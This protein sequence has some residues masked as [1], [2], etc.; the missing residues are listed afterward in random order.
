M[1]LFEILYRSPA[2]Y[3]LASTLGFRGYWRLWQRLALRYV[4]RG[5]L[6]DLG[7]GLG[8]LTREAAASG[9]TAIGIDRSPAMVEA[10]R[11]RVA[12]AVK[13]PAFILADVRAL[14]FPDGV[15]D[16]L[17][18]A[19]PTGV[20]FQPAVGREAFRVLKPGS[21]AAIVLGATL[22]PS[23]L[24]NAMA[25]VAHRA[26]YGSMAGNVPREPPD[27]PFVA[28]GLEQSYVVVERPSW[29]AWLV[30]V[31]KPA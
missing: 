16:A 5:L 7:C 18:M 31:R 2:L 9:W 30:V 26:V 11:R 3:R 15:A 20:V 1:P 17:T 22:R 25:L 8:D 14:P 28:A 21:R 19:F 12:R 13:R 10:A 29:A 4:G 27:L 6:L 23:S 24:A